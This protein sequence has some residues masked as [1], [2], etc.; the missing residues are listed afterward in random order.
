MSKSK[1]DPRIYE[2]LKEKTKSSLKESSIRPSLSYIRQKYPFLTLN[3]A[4]EVFAKERGFNV[5]GYLTDEDRK[6]LTHL[7]F[8]PVQTIKTSNNKKKIETIVSYETKNK[9]L[10]SLMDEI[11]RSYTFGC[12]TA[13]FVLCRKLL[14][15]LLIH[16]IIRKKYPGNSLSERELYY[17]I[18]RKRYHDFSKILVNL[19]NHSADFGPEQNIIDRICQL[20]DGY[21]ETANEM[22]HSLYHI[23]KK[24]EITDKKIQDIIDLIAQVEKTL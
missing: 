17:D 19:Q 12:Y 10:K 18:H 2:I 9:W 8:K 16:N 24:K 7:Q 13:C 14:E 6:T 20:S 22:T 15:N 1:L 5:T 3:A 4:A 21:K 23:A 11:N